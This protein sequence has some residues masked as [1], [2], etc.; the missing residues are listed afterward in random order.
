MASASAEPCT[1]RTQSRMMDAD[2]VDGRMMIPKSLMNAVDAARPVCTFYRRGQCKKGSK[3]KLFHGRAQDTHNLPSVSR[4]NTP[5]GHRLQIRAPVKKMLD[6]YYEEKGITSPIGSHKRVKGTPILEFQLIHGTMEEPK[7][8]ECARAQLQGQVIVQELSV[9]A[10]PLSKLLPPKQVGQSTKIPF[11]DMLAH[12]TETQAALQITVDG[13]IT[14]SEGIAGNGVYGFEVKLDKDGNITEEEL[15]R[16]WDMS[17]SGGYNKG[18]VILFRPKQGALI[19]GKAALRLPPGTVAFKDPNK[20]NKR[21]QYAAHPSTIEYVT[22]LWHEDALVELLGHKLE[23]SKYTVEL[24]KALADVRD[25][26]N[27]SREKDIQLASNLVEVDNPI[28]ADGSHQQTN[29]GPP[30]TSAADIEEEMIWVD[31]FYVSDMLAK[32]KEGQTF[33]VNGE[34]LGLQGQFAHGHQASSGA[35]SSSGNSPMHGHHRHQAPHQ[36]Q[37]Q[38]QQAPQQAQQMNSPNWTEQELQQFW[39][40]QQL[41]SYSQAQSRRQQA[42][43][44]NAYKHEEYGVWPRSYVPN[45]SPFDVG[46]EQ[47]AYVN[48][49]FYNKTEGNRTSISSSRSSGASKETAT[50]AEKHGEKEVQQEDEDDSWQPPAKQAKKAQKQRRGRSA[51]ASNPPL[52]GSA[53]REVSKQRAQ[54]ESGDKRARPEAKA[55]PAKKTVMMTAKL[56]STGIDKINVALPDRKT[57]SADTKLDYDTNLQKAIQKAL[58]KKKDFDIPRVDILVDLQDFEDP[59][60]KK[61]SAHWG[62]HVKIIEGFVNSPKF[63]VEIGKVREKIVRLLRTDKRPL[64]NTLHIVAVCRSGRHR[65]VAF[66]KALDWIFEHE[67][68]ASESWHTTQRSWGSLCVSCKKCWG[69]GKEKDWLQSRV[70]KTWNDLKASD[71]GARHLS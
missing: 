57:L 51:G 13:G 15:K 61:Y 22:I 70:L 64:D 26:T 32:A 58:I 12:G 69:Y 16:I 39:G 66:V 4:Y 24:H 34:R 67:R 40:G 1:A 59:E 21:I 25:Y 52:R 62:E 43:P 71:D 30:K 63:A 45:V 41:Q 18:A 38:P 2:T 20:D 17:A 50:R 42:W 10:N 31:P 28:V 48:A 36:P 11:P 6:V 37:P 7:A 44:A 56:Y 68:W 49:T 53:A 55:R 46:L 8:E 23:G 60:S 19:N 29:W 54:S 27:G 14:A 35:S 9:S 5:E 65:S 47:P 3:C 33:T